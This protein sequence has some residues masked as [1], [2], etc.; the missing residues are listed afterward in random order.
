MVE[1]QKTHASLNREEFGEAYGTGFDR[2]VHFLLSRGAPRDHATDIAQAAWLRG[3]ERLSQ[4]RD[5]STVVNW[6]NTIALNMF[7]RVIRAESRTGVLQDMASPV[8]AVNWAAIDLSRILGNCR[9][10]DRSLLHAQLIGRTA[11]EIA[12]QEG[13]TQ[14]A[15]RLR[16]LRARRA[17]RQVAETMPM[18]MAAR[19][20]AA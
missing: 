6:V 2:T 13:T 1:I 15:I 10:A 20:L 8:P 5:A 18:Q 17:A 9:P 11:Q 14:T 4:L 7:R 12:R 19:R 3:W 16:F